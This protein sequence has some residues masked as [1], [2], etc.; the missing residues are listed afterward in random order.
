M[1]KLFGQK[2]RE[3]RKARGL[4]GKQLGALSGLGQGNM[5]NI[6]R[7]VR[8]PSDQNL[9]DLVKVAE[10]GVT[11][12]QL[13]AWRAADRAT[14]EGIAKIRAHAPELLDP[15]GAVVATL[16]DEMEN[17]P[18]AWELKTLARIGALDGG[19]LDPRSGSYVWSL[20]KDERKR[21]IIQARKDWEEAH[22]SVEDGVA[23]G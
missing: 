22:G 19:E 6:E 8:P 7:G 2:L 3:H 16:P 23:K 13:E 14:P 18:D 1:G 17:P 9:A 11:L 4:S 21:L 20:P 5:N 15:I 10:L 12:E